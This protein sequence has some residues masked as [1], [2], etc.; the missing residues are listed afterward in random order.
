MDNLITKE[1][2]SAVAA[3]GSNRLKDM[4]FTWKDERMKSVKPWAQFT[5]KTKF[6]PPKPT[7]LVVRMKSNVSYFLSNYIIL[8]FILALYCVITNP[9]FLFSIAISVLLY[10]YLFRWRQEPIV[11]AGYTASDRVKFG[12]L[13]VVSIFLFWYA[14]VGNT[15]FWLI[16][17]SAVIVFFH[18]LLYTP[19]E[20]TDY[21]FTSKSF[22]GLGVTGTVNV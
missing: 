17:A 13:A 9:F 4:F 18:A 2:A 6:S 15:I 5:D 1:T 10:F 21:D 20:E 8:F 3:A 12:M 14:S 16:G 7:E 11:I 19:V 22:D